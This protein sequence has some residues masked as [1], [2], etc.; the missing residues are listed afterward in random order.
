MV[1]V[2]ALLAEVAPFGLGPLHAAHNFS[3][4]LHAVHTL[5]GVLHAVHCFRGVLHA[6]D[7]IHG[8]LLLFRTLLSSLLLRLPQLHFL[9]VLGLQ[10]VR[11]LNHDVQGVRKQSQREHRGK[12][13]VQRVVRKARAQLTCGDVRGTVRVCTHATQPACVPLCTLR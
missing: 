1:C 2:R 3:C 10:L 5:R 6:I 11:K 13:V 9:V 7:D 8:V 12:D 4:A